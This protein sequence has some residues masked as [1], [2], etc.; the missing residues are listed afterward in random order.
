SPAK[1]P[2]SP[3]S[4]RAARSKFIEDLQDATVEEKLQQYDDLA[5]E[6]GSLSSR[7]ASLRA[8]GKD[9]PKDLNR[10]V[11]RNRNQLDALRTHLVEQHDQN[12]EELQDRA[13]RLRGQTKDEKTAAPKVQAEQTL[14]ATLEDLP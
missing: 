6:A 3:S 5:R 7:A 14:R 2:V 9:I 8:G 13:R 12:K 1:D 10:K 4:R 11:L